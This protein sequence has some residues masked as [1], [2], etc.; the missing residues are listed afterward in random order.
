MPI[1]QMTHLILL[2]GGPMRTGLQ[3]GGLHCRMCSRRLANQCRNL[4]AGGLPATALA[5][6]ATA[7]SY[8]CT[9]AAA[10]ASHRPQRNGASRKA[11]AAGRQPLVGRCLYISNE[12][13]EPL[14]APPDPDL[15]AKFQASDPS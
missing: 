4:H 7:S 2:W 9:R 5:F 8:A 10:A 14:Q 3:N 12:T 11:P 13:S 15:G 6:A 1:G